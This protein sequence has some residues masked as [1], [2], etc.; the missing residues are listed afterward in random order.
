MDLFNDKPPKVLV[1]QKLCTGEDVCKANPL[2]IKKQNDAIP[3]IKNRHISKSR[4]KTVHSA[5]IRSSSPS[6]VRKSAIV[7]TSVPM[8]AQSAERKRPNTNSKKSSSAPS[9]P[10]RR[11]TLPS[12]TNSTPSTPPSSVCDGTVEKQIPSRRAFGGRATD[13]LWPSMKSLSSSFQ[14]ESFGCVSKKD[15]QVRSTSLDHTLKNATKAASERKRIPLIGRNTSEQSEN[16]SLVQHRWAAMKG[17]KVSTMAF[18]RS[19]NLTDKIEKAASLMLQSRGLSPTRNIPVTDGTSRSIHKSSNRT[20]NVTSPHVEEEKALPSTNPSRTLSLPAVTLCRPSSPMNVSMLSSSA[21]KRIPSPSSSRPSSPFIS[22]NNAMNQI[23]SSSMVLG[24]ILDKRKG[25]KGAEM[26]DIHQL[27]LLYNRELQWRFV[28]CQAEV[29]LATQKIAA[30]NI[31]KNVWNA[32]SELQ[33]SVTVEKINIES[34]KQ[35]MKLEMLLKEQATSLEDWIA[36]EGEYS[37]SLFGTIEALKASML[38]LPVTGGA[39]VDLR[40]VKN[41]VSSAIDIMQAMGSSVCSLLSRVEGTRRLLCQLSA[42]AA[43]EK[44]MLDECR[45]LLAATAGMQV[46]E[47]SLRA[48]LLNNRRDDDNNGAKITI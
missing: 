41:A 2:K 14:S 15:R 6:L 3:K 23:G 13:G 36:L 16:S 18:S 40:A 9:S 12:P 30:E 26:E 4:S 43:K 5:T 47:C 39:R 32:T 8:R 29:A 35:E 1:K 33:D 10:L 42:V 28:N 34:L 20:V 19:V 11:P 38:R 22:S 25:T 27:R 17:G 45:V 48:H 21:P 31:C 24:H 46:E 37:N 7:D 44:A